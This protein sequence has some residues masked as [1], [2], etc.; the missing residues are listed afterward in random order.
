MR[1]SEIVD[2][3][4]ELAGWPLRATENSPRKLVR[5]AGVLGFAVLFFPVMLLWIVVGGFLGIPAMIQDA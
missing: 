5:V 1:L 2:A 4:P 3:I